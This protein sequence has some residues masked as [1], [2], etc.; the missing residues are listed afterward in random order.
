MNKQQHHN[1]FVLKQSGY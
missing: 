1:A